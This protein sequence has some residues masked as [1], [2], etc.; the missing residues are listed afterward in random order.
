MRGVE[1]GFNILL[2]RTRDLA[3]HLAVHRREILE[4]PAGARLGPFAP[5]EVA[6]AL[7]EGSFRG[8]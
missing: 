7:F 4:V 1:R 5:D 8:A 6:V 3:K 2:V